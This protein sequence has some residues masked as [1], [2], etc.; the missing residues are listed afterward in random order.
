M[1]FQSTFAHWDH[2]W[3]L[4]TP[5]HSVYESIEAASKKSPSGQ[6]VVWI[7][8]TERAG[9][10]RQVH[11]FNDPRTAMH[12]QGEVYYR[13][14]SYQT[15]GSSGEPLDLAIRFKDK[16]DADVEWT[17]SIGG[18]PGF[19]A[20]G[21]GLTDQSGHGATRFFL[22]FFREKSLRATNSRLTIGGA[23]FSFPR[24]PALASKYRFQAAYSHNNFFASIP[25]GGGRVAIADQ[26]MT[27]P[28]GGGLTL[29]R[30]PDAPMVY[31]AHSPD[32][33]R[34]AVVTFD[35]DGQ[36]LAYEQIDRGHTFRIM[37][38][39]PLPTRDGGRAGYS[40]AF[41]AFHRLIEGV[42]TVTRNGDA[43]SVEWHH[44]KPGWTH[45]YHFTSSLRAIGPTGYELIVASEGR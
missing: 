11:Y 30:W 18:S 4:W 9:N 12:F 39:Q 21:A 3:F 27:L 34:D 38:D 23:D 29:F 26:R 15:N 45:G 37:L 35:S 36:L 17:V 5:K 10:K 13:A 42:A 6:D 20:Q 43:V 24:D 19:E 1:P 28:I 25:Y 2:H 8:F 31:R 14:L 16:D 32:T 40:V 22:I 7:W 44:E 33:G 41:D